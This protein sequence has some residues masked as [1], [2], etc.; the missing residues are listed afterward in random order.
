LIKSKPNSVFGQEMGSNNEKNKKK[1]NLIIFKLKLRAR[2]VGDGVWER[3]TA[4]KKLFKPRHNSAAIL[5][6]RHAHA[7]RSQGDK[8]DTVSRGAFCGCELG[9]GAHRLPPPRPCGRGDVAKARLGHLARI[10]DCL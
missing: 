1:D 8:D 5:L 10:H 4:V 7:R 6:Y 3:F 2:V 9:D